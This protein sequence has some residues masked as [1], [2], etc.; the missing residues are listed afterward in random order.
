M[1][2]TKEQ[3]EKLAYDARRKYQDD[4]SHKENGMNDQIMFDA[5]KIE[6]G[7]IDGYNACNEL[8]RMQLAGI[9]TAS[10]GY[11]KT[12]DEILEEYDTVALRDTAKLYQEY[13][14]LFKLNNEKK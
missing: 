4:A 1:E 10:I 14:K 7:F 11:W 9:S 3:I 8:R 6:R 13:D 12:S 5:M 2:K